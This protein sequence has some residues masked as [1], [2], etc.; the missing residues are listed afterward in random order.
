MQIQC[1]QWWKWDGWTVRAGDPPARTKRG[2]KVGC[3]HLGPALYILIR[4]RSIIVT[5]VLGHLCEGSLVQ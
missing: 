1:R 2:A 4:P 3:L 5:S